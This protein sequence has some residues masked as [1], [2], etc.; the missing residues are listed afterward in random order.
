MSIETVALAHV[1]GGGGVG[2]GGVGGGVVGVIV[3]AK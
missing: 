3:P 2:E 1:A